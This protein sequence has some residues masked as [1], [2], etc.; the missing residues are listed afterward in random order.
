[1]FWMIFHFAWAN[2]IFGHKAVVFPVLKFL[3]I[4][5]CGYYY[6]FL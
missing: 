5:S 6:Y 1:M 4:N 3:C 2:V